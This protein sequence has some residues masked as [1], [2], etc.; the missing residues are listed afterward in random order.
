[1]PAI[2]RA[3]A[4]K[5]AAL[6][7]GLACR[8]ASRT[9]ADRLTEE[10]GAHASGLVAAR[11]QAARHYMAYEAVLDPI[12]ELAR[13]QG[14]PVVLLKG[15]AL[16]AAGIA[17]LG[18]RD[19]GDLDIL[20]D[21]DSVAEFSAGL[22]AAGFST[23]PGSRNEQH[24]PP[25]RAP[26]WGVVDVHDALRGVV[27]PTSNWLDASG[28]LAVGRPTEVRPGCWVPDRQVLA[29]HALAHGLEQ[30]ATSPGAYPLLRTLGDL[31][32]I[33]GDEQGWQ[34]ALPLLHRHVGE[35]L[36]EGEIVATR[37]LCLALQRGAA[38]E[39]SDSPAGRLLAHFLAHTFDPEYRADLRGAHRRYR[40]LHALRHGTL[41]RYIHRKLSDWWRRFH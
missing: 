9:P 37:D 26:V 2:P 8:I 6:R 31:I 41:V 15:F 16:N 28:V 22:E 12:S 19:V 27:G 33:V 30:H 23:A 20:V 3:E 35:T 38:P 32:D 25:M 40:L 17:A 10:L 18:S 21:R 14:R 13:A 11:R 39:D 34:E 24:L 1:M 29:A 5:L 36:R 7:S 4:A